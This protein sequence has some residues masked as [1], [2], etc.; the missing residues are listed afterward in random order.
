MP[1]WDQASFQLKLTPDCSL[2]GFLCSWILYN[3]FI[4]CS[5][6]I[7]LTVY[8][9]HTIFFCCSPVDWLCVPSHQQ[10]SRFGNDNGAVSARN[11]LLSA[12][13]AWAHKV[14]SASYNM[15]IKLPLPAHSAGCFALQRLAQRYNVAAQLSIIY[16]P[17]KWSIP[18]SSLESLLDFQAVSRT[19]RRLMFKNHPHFN[20][21]LSLIPLGSTALFQTNIIRL[22]EMTFESNPWLKSFVSSIFSIN[23]HLL[24][25]KWLNSF[26]N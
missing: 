10:H 22:P 9:L 13:H 24:A 21:C 12:S 8:P 20:Q 6:L 15:H 16:P 2:L 23:P 17:S 18:L 1:K 26:K 19:D 7:C 14:G 4:T 25:I 3:P 11:R 5:S